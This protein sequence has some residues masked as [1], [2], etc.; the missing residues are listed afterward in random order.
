MKER[1]KQTALKN[2]INSY[3]PKGKVYD[4][5]TSD[6]LP[7][8][9][10]EVKPIDKN[11]DKVCLV[12]GELGKL[13]Y[14]FLWEMKESYTLTGENSDMTDKE[15]K[16]LVAFASTIKLP[17]GYDIYVNSHMKDTVLMT[18]NCYAYGSAKI[19]IKK[20]KDGSGYRINITIN[21]LM[22]DFKK[23]ASVL[24]ENMP[25]VFENIA[26]KEDGYVVIKLTLSNHFY[27]FK[28]T[29]TTESRLMKLKDIR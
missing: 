8:T 25:D 29:D 6:L 22:K 23:V 20:D 18:V 15:V 17:H 4:V 10:I 13:N 27:M 3:A 26:F 9:T 7:F 14:E 12:F 1:L 11:R 16:K 2:V 19:T 28:L 21:N 24:I 5:I